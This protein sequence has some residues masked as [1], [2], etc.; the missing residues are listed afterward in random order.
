[1]PLF[2][3]DGPLTEDNRK[4]LV[5]QAAFMVLS[6]V[7]LIHV[8]H[9]HLTKT[10]G[11]SFTP[12]CSPGEMYAQQHAQQEMFSGDLYGGFWNDVDDDTQQFFLT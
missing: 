8:H 6:T 10:G 2:V 7:Y 5:F 12:I 3:M 1:M 4:N 9:L 11:C